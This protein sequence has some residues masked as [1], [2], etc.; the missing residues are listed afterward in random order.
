MLPFKA[1]SYCSLIDFFFSFHVKTYMYST[2]P[3]LIFRC[4]LAVN[5]VT[6]DAAL[7]LHSSGTEWIRTASDLVSSSLILQLNGPVPTAATQSGSLLSILHHLDSSQGFCYSHASLIYTNQTNP[8]CLEETQPSPW[9]SFARPPSL[10]KKKKC[11]FIV[12]KAN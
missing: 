11:R 5:S 4:S 2:F 6:T 9:L 10:K 3:A 8:N 7:V 1:A 12:I